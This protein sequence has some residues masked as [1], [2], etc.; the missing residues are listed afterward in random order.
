M[1]ADIWDLL[2]SIIIHTDRQVQIIMTLVIRFK[3]V[4]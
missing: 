1:Q 4:S 2:K 3:S